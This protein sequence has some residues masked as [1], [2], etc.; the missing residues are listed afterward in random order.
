VSV[1]SDVADVRVMGKGADGYAEAVSA[2]IDLAEA[3]EPQGK[4]QDGTI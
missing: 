1:V 4:G 3:D 2:L